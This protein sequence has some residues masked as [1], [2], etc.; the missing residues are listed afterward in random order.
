MQVDHELKPYHPANPDYGYGV[1][2]RES[3]R[4]GVLDEHPI[5]RYCIEMTACDT[6]KFALVWLKLILCEEKVYHIVYHC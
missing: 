3:D 5:M 6:H 4:R 2:V 1:A